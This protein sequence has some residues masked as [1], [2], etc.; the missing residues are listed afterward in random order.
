M[1]DRHTYHRDALGAATVRIETRDADGSELGS[2]TGFFVTENWVL[3]CAHVV[4]DGH[5]RVFYDGQELDA[6]VLQRD[7]ENGDFSSRDG[8]LY[9]LPD[10]ALLKVEATSRPLP[11]H[12][13]VELQRV[14]PKKD[15]RLFAWGWPSIAGQPMWEGME[16]DFEALRYVERPSHPLLKTTCGQVQP[17]ASGAPVVHLDSGVVIGL[18]KLTRDKSSSA[19]ALVVPTGMILDAL[20]HHDLEAANRRAAPSDENASMEAHRRRLGRV[21]A[22]VRDELAD[23][24]D[25]WRR[26]M[27]AAWAVETAGPV[28]SED[29]ALALLGIPLEQLCVALRALSGARHN[30]DKAC[31]LLRYAACCSW[32][33]SRPWVAP[34]GAALLA[35][36]RDASSPRVVHISCTDGLTLEWYVRRAPVWGMDWQAVPLSAPDAETDPGTGLPV[37]LVHSIRVE[38]LHDTTWVEDPNDT[39]AVEAL[40]RR[41]GSQ[42]LQ[43]ARNRVFVLPGGSSDVDRGL[44]DRLQQHFPACLFVISAQRVSPGI[45]RFPRLVSLPVSLSAADEEQAVEDYQDTKYQVEL[46]ADL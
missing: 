13:C 34:D 39:R 30:A 41:K 8:S 38:L 22:R 27:L 9:A 24:P 21:L 31:M 18:I 36:E 3:T 6:E 37:R 46:A 14:T 10:V 15:D 5:T 19:G 2:G 7:P 1:I 43:H 40:W 32:V 33:R 42:A 28:D 35:R 29:L 20:A 45:R 16:M 11:D 23:V 44:L 4:P 12:A 17:G 25:E 26:S